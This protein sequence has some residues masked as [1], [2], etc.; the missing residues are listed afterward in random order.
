MPVD[1]GFWYVPDS[2]DEI[3]GSSFQQLMLGWL[4]KLTIAIKH[5]VVFYYEGISGD[6]QKIEDLREY[7]GISPI[8]GKYRR[9]DAKA[10]RCRNQDGVYAGLS[11][12]YYNGKERSRKI[13]SNKYLLKDGIEI[14]YD[15]YVCEYL[16]LGEWII[17]IY[18][19]SRWYGAFI[20]GQ[21]INEDNLNKIKIKLKKEGINIPDEGLKP[22]DP[23]DTVK[24]EFFYLIHEFMKYFMER[25]DYTSGKPLRDLHKILE[26]MQPYLLGQINFSESF[27]PF[28]NDDLNKVFQQLTDYFRVNRTNLYESLIY[29][30]E[31][32]GLKGLHVFKAKSKVEEIKGKPEI[33]SAIL[34]D[35]HLIEQKTSDRTRKFPECPYTIS[36][37]K[38]ISRFEDIKDDV[39]IKHFTE[40]EPDIIKD[41]M[42]NNENCILP[43]FEN[44]FMIANAYAGY[45]EFPII[46]ICFFGNAYEKYRYISIMNELDVLRQASIIY[47]THWHAIYVNY[48]SCINSIMSSFVNHELDNTLAGMKADLGKLSKE[49]YEEIVPS[50]IN[51]NKEII[52]LFRA[53]D[54]FI[55]LL[56]EYIPNAERNNVL[57][58]LIR[59]MTNSS[60]LTNSPDKK[61]FDQGNLLIKMMYTYQ[62]MFKDADMSLISDM[63]ITRSASQP[64][65]Y[66]DQRLFEIIVNNL[67]RNAIK[68]AH[69]KTKEYFNLRYIL[70]ADK[71]REDVYRLIVTSYGIPISEDEYEKIFELGYR[72]P[73]AKQI[74]KAGMGIGLYLVKKLAELHNGECRVVSTKICDYH[75]TLL[76]FLNNKT[77]ANMMDF[78]D[79][80]KKA[81]NNAYIDLKNKYPNEVD[82]AYFRGRGDYSIFR[83][84]E[85]NIN[86]PTARNEFTV[87]FPQPIRRYS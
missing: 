11:R 57:L 74:D 15:A 20:I 56:D 4:Y 65:I 68:Y 49:F 31:K 30:K 29:F 8:C 78:T 43:N 32:I 83:Y 54:S 47:L 39:A 46:Y 77:I 10:D 73:V 55:D 69:K 7:E 50:N 27:K 75:V 14:N 76:Y 58:S 63:T 64:T 79:E 24:D 87:D 44:A 1:K 12:D 36:G 28:K 17:P 53:M 37:E 40:T 5:P 9:D 19:N 33:E 61:E 86:R 45:C 42:V 71:T 70:T 62:P 60:L 72:S 51:R 41:F 3:I 21:F 80:Q 6:L 35:L 52:Y 2:I 13:T 82:K 18:I 23:N 26:G 66:A 25:I 38:L 84:I 67:I 59:D 48:Q 85:K 81:Y 16:G 22:S 34:D